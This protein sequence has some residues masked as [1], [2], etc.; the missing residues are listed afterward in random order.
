MTVPHP[1]LPTSH[2]RPAVCARGSGFGGR[3]NQDEV[4]KASGQGILDSALGC[5]LQRTGWRYRGES[6]LGRGI[7]DRVGQAAVGR[8]EESR[9]AGPRREVPQPGGSCW[10]A[11]LAGPSSVA[12]VLCGSSQQ[13]ARRNAAWMVSQGM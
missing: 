5:T 8:V 6:G 10:P 3:R 2:L 12:I 7:P 11:G 1:P 13:P 4:L 9:L